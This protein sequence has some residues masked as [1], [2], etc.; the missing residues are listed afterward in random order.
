MTRAEEILNKSTLDEAA[1]KLTVRIRNKKV[2]RKLICPPFFKKHGMACLKLTASDAKKL[3][4]MRKKQ[5]KRKMRQKIKQII[6]KRAVSMGIR[7][8]IVGDKDIK[9]DDK[10]SRNDKS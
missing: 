5:F 4:R 3:T 10:G 1:A 8:A 2:Q 9:I 6:K 7:G